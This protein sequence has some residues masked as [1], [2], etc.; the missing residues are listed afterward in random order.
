[1][2]LSGIKVLVWATFLTLAGVNY[3]RQ[4][5]NQSTDGHVVQKGVN[6]SNYLQMLFFRFYHGIFRHHSV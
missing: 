3:I 6:N 1:M 2:Y 5:L 4:G